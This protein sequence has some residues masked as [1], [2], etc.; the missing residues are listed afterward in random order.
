MYTLWMFLFTNMLDMK[1][2]PGVSCIQQPK[3][4]LIVEYTYWNVI[5][6]F[7]NWNIIQFINKTT[8]SEYFD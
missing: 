4:Q 5:G 6:A 2:A 1:W 8:S 3:Y 7:K